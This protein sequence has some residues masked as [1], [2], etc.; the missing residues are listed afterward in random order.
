MPIP[1][2]N[3][4]WRASTNQKP[5]YKKMEDEKIFGG[6][7]GQGRGYIWGFALAL[8][9]ILKKRSEKQPNADTGFLRVFVSFTDKE[10]Y[11]LYFDFANF[12]FDHYALGDSTSE[13]F[14]DMDKIAEAG[15]EFLM[16]ESEKQGLPNVDMSQIIQAV[17]DQTQ[18]T[19]T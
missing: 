7:T 18:P 15:I 1:L 19:T 12:I 10:K 3:I 6:G 9:Y 17:K 13:K 4:G 14:K 11:P 5:F 16:S 8:G 2:E